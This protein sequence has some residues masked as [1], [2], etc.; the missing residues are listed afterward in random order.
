VTCQAPPFVN[1]VLRPSTVLVALVVVV[2]ALLVHILILVVLLHVLLVL[3]VPTVWRASS[4]VASVPL[5]HLVIILVP[6]VVPIVL[7]VPTITKQAL[8]LVLHVLPTQSVP[9]ER[10]VVHL[11][12]LVYVPMTAYDVCSVLLRHP[13]I[14]PRLSVQL[15]NTVPRAI[16]PV[17]L[18]LVPRIQTTQVLLNVTMLL[19]VLILFSITLHMLHVQLWRFS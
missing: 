10:L 19:L 12:L 13:T 6:L 1:N 14:P 15:A 16:L 5:E 7:K 4:S 9:V 2:T 8:L 18:V 17:R 11:V 3:L